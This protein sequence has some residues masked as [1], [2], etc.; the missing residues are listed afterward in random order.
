VIP[1][2]IKETNS[3]FR[4]FMSITLSVSYD[5]TPLDISQADEKESYAENNQQCEIDQHGHRITNAEGAMENVGAVSRRKHV[6]K[7]PEKNRQTLNRE[8]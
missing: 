2:I 8:E 4:S 3:F 7:R 1:R 6:R 5:P